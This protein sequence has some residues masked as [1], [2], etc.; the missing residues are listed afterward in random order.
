MPVLNTFGILPHM[1][2]SPVFQYALVAEPSP[3]LISTPASRPN[4][5]LQWN[6]KTNHQRAL[7]DAALTISQMKTSYWRINPPFHRF[8]YQFR[9]ICFV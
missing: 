8:L 4:T 6:I 2:H 1:S 5:H 3:S 9:S 7:T